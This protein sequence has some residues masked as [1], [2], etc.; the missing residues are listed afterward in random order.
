MESQT[1]L[2]CAKF[3]SKRAKCALE[4]SLPAAIL[5]AILLIQIPQIDLAL[6][7]LF[8]RAKDAGFPAHVSGFWL[9]HSPVLVR[10]YHAIDVISRIALIVSALMLIWYLF[11]KNAKAFYATVVLVSLIVGPMLAVNAG[12]KETWGRARPR[13]VVEFEGSLKFTPAW[14]ISD[15]CTHN[16]SFT[17]GH[18]AAGFS[19]CIGFFVSRR[20]IWLNGGL[21]FGG[22]VSLS[23]MMNGA[24]FFS[25][26]LFSF[27][28]VFISAAI[29]TW[30]LAALTLRCLKI[31]VK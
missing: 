16:C 1:L 14:V 31:K 7:A 12:L 17:S 25:D 3:S 15:Q 10:F 11:R 29:M 4:Y 13:D 24:H 6:S 30:L 2:E 27:F 22:L 9:S 28:V 18:A 19:V 20:K 23:R 8:F 21:L 26:V 5:F